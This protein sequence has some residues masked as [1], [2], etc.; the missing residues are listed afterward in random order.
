MRSPPNPQKNPHS[1]LYNG[2]YMV[3]ICIL[4]LLTSFAGLNSYWCCQRFLLSQGRVLLV[5]YMF[6]FVVQYWLSLV[7]LSWSFY[8]G[9]VPMKYHY[10]VPDVTRRTVGARFI[11]GWRL[12]AFDVVCWCMFVGIGKCPPGGPPG[13]LRMLDMVRPVLVQVWRMMRGR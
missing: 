12:V 1:S 6:L 9:S 7:L 2:I 10:R 11:W 13:H 3:I 5:L 8:D 4:L